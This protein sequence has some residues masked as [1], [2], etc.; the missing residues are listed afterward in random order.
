MLL[1]FGGPSSPPLV[2]TMSW[3][4]IRPERLDWLSGG[5]WGVLV[6][7][8]CGVFPAASAPEPWSLTSIIYS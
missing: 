6:G 2:H 4:T 1:S 7:C 5:V 3:M 8:W